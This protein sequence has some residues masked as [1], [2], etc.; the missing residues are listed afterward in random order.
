MSRASVSSQAMSHASRASS[1]LIVT[2]PILRRALDAAASRVRPARARS[3]SSICRWMSSSSARSRSIW[4]SRSKYRSL[5][6]RRVHIELSLLHD[7]RDRRDETLK[8]SRFLREPLAA[9]GRDLVE[10]RAA[11]VARFTPFGLDPAVHE[12]T[13]QRRVE[14]AFADLQDVAGH[15]FEAPGD[16]VAVRLLARQRLE[17]EHLESAG[18]QLSAEGAF[19]HRWMIHRSSMH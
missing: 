19:T 12:E 11:A 15:L 2:L 6:R 5:L 18:Q 7:R 1:R 8:A 14:R 16:G 13:L 9:G 4:R 17:D 3:A 10:A